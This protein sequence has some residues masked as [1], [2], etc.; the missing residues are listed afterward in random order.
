MYYVFAVILHASDWLSYY[1]SQVSIVEE[2]EDGDPNMFVH[3]EVPLS[4]FPLCTAWMDFNRENGDEK[5]KIV[6]PRGF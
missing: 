4:D 3:H 1:I 2:L 5:G 6:V